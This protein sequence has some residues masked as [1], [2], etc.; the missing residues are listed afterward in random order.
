[1]LGKPSEFIRTPKFGLASPNDASWKTMTART[2]GKFQMLPFVEL[3][4]GS[5][6]LAC[7]VVS[8]LRYR[9]ITFSIPFL[10]LFMAGYFYVGIAT[11]RSLYCTRAP[12]AQLPKPNPLTRTV[13]LPTSPLPGALKISPESSLKTPRQTAR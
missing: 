12:A 13:N 8:L 4:F 6:L 11:L 3:L 2:R 7:I 9:Q 10:G 1:M 5:Y